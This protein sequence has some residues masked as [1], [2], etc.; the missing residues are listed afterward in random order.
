[1]PSPQSRPSR[2]PPIRIRSPVTSSAIAKPAL[3]SPSNFVSGQHCFTGAKSP[4]QG[5]F[6]GAIGLD[7][8]TCARAKTHNEFANRRNKPLTAPHCWTEEPAA[9]IIGVLP[10]QT[11]VAFCW[12]CFLTCG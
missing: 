2:V 12:A 3:H 8:V 5:L 11:E 6:D 7:F 1:M 4:N 10:F 9:W